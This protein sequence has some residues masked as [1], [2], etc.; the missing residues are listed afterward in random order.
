MGTHVL[1]FSS[2]SPSVFHFEIAAH[3]FPDCLTFVGLLSE[4]GICGECP[5]YRRSGCRGS[6]GFSLYCFCCISLV[7]VFV[8]H[9]GCPSDG[10][11]PLMEER[12]STDSLDSLTG[13]KRA[14]AEILKLPSL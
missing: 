10:V 6:L 11:L 7:I 4:S 9:V 13:S 1:D 3:K 5:I 12:L 14:T 2:P 8:V